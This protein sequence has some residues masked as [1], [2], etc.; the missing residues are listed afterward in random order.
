M[1]GFNGGLI[2]KDRS[3]TSAA[4]VPGVWTLGEHIKAKRNN[5]WPLLGPGTISLPFEQPS[6][7]TGFPSG[8]YYYKPTG[9]TGSAF[10]AYTD[11][12]TAGGPWA[13]AWI[14]TNVTGDGTDWW[15]GDSSM[16]GATGTNH[17]T[18]TSTLGS[19]ASGTSKANAKN[20][21]FDFYSFTKMMIVENHQGTLGTKRY[22]LTTNSSFKTLFNTAESSGNNIVSSVLGSSG[23]FT[24]FTTNTLYLNTGLTMSTMSGDGGRLLATLSSSEASGGI[25]AR[26]DGGRGYGWKGNLTRSDAN[27]SYGSDGTTTDHTVWIYV[28]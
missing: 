15:D 14:V 20:P 3:T 19:T 17:F 10:E 23:S 7:A 1:I 18:T 4:S 21:F 22:S 8:T 5:T 9:Y 12:G 11:C 24:T 27:R 25:S 13:L 6:D 2:G 28:A 26:V 16:G